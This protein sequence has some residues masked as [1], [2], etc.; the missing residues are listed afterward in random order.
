M[1]SRAYWQMVDRLQIPDAM[2]LEII[3]CPGKLPLTGRRPRFR[4]NT[5]Q[6]RLAAYLPEIEIALQSI[7]ESP[8]WL[9][10]RSRVVPFSGRTPLDLMAQR[11]GE[12]VAEVGFLTR[13]VMRKSLR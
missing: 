11:D 7:N 4:L 3:G 1:T 12:G 8:D 2:A 5:R 6:S 9:R 13:A 10:R